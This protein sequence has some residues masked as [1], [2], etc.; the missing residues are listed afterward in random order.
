M[1]QITSRQRVGRRGVALVSGFLA[2]VTTASPQ[3]HGARPIRNLQPASVI[4]IRTSTQSA[5]GIAC[6]DVRDITAIGM[7]W[8]AL[9]DC[10][11]Q[12]SALV[13]ADGKSTHFLN[14]EER[15]DRVVMDASLNM[16]LRSVPATSAN[17]TIGTTRALVLDATGA[18]VRR[19]AINSR[20]AR[21]FQVAGSI[22]WASQSGSLTEVQLNS[23]DVAHLS[24]YVDTNRNTP[25]LIYVLG[26]PGGGH[27][28]IGNLT[29]TVNVFD[30]QN[31]LVASRLLPLD[32]VYKA[33][34]MPIRPP[35]IE[36]GRTR[37]VWAAGASTGLVYICLS[38][39]PMSGPAYVAV[40]DPL[41]G[42]LTGVI[43]A[44]LPKASGRVDPRFNPAGVIVP[45]LGAIDGHLI[46]AD[47]E[48]QVLAVY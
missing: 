28:T 13:W 3:G 41:A 45:G 12:K 6:D 31:R 16:V 20:G 8:A 40:V 44:D 1:P 39:T 35:D 32:E 33:I 47:R 43:R 21:P 17:A 7:R 23:P 36:S 38:D 4:D 34:G 27:A 22:R 48:M 24:T 42:A 29:E 46:I 26:L 5:S 30:E 37:M 10:P 25:Q 11:A 14:L 18:V 15:F 9:L 2:F 19:V